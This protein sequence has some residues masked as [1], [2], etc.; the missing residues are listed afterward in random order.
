MTDT[1]G[2]PRTRALAAALRR[3]MEE[4]GFGVR[5]VARVLGLSHSTVSQWVNGRRVP[6]PDSVSALLAVI[7][8][9]GRKRADIL[10]LAHNAADPNWL[11]VGP[12]MSNQLAGLI[13]CEQTAT[14][15]IEWT[16]WLVTGLLQ[17]PAYIRSIMEWSPRRSPEAADRSVSIR[18]D[19]Q[20]VLRD[21][22]PAPA[23]LTAFIGEPA[24]RQIIGGRTTMFDQLDHLLTV[25]SLP[26]VSV[27]IVR[28]GEGWHPGLIGPFLLYRFAQSPSILHFEHFGSSVFVYGK[29]DIENHAPAVDALDHIAL[30]EQHSM[31]MITAAIADLEA[32][33]G[34]KPLAQE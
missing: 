16:P 31:T 6:T 14:E 28:I 33:H 7:R 15:I 1:G 9:T 22:R 21:R 27:R 23:K 29:D 20:R 11:A 4:S 8:V 26:N 19:R 13:E 5:E 17:M 25:A 34:P 12:G 10:E 18:I 24:I 2:T 30:S 3:E 32:G